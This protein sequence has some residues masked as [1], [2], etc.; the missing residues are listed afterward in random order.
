MVFSH[1]IHK[2]HGN[3]KITVCGF[4][5][6]RGLVVFVLDDERRGDLTPANVM[7]NGRLQTAPT[8]WQL[9]ID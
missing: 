6:V 8:V 1:G 7:R 9:G 2:T 3:L 5:G 4:R